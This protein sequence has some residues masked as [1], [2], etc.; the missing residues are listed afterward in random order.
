[1][2]V[3][4]RSPLIEPVQI[5]NLRQ[6]FRRIIVFVSALFILQRVSYNELSERIGAVINAFFFAVANCKVGYH[7][8]KF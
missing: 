7:H 4:L 2:F 1:M 6:T 8:K 3:Y 5:S